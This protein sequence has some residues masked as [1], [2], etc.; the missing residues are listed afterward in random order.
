MK[1]RAKTLCVLFFVFVF[2]EFFGDF[3]I[4]VGLKVFAWFCGFWFFAFSRM[5][6]CAAVHFF[7]GFWFLHFRVYFRGLLCAFVCGFVVCWS[8]CGCLGFLVFCCC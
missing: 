2:W 7:V 4:F 3:C 5:V 8:F 6:L 1:G